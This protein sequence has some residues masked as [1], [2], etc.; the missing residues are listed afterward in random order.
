MPAYRN[1]FE[2]KVAAQLGD[3]F[4]YETHQLPY[5][6]KHK[7]KADFIDAAAKKIVEAKGRF[8]QSDRAKMLAVKKQNPDWHITIVF[9]NPDAKLD[10]RSNTSYSEWC[11]K[12]GIAW[13]KA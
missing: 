12:Q 2:S 9:Q 6:T 4:T 13:R 8:P 5:T 1:K 3:T 11:D 7:Y 10:K